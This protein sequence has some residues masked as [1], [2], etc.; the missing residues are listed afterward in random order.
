MLNI[1]ISIYQ[2]FLTVQVLEPRIFHFSLP[3]HLDK[4]LEHIWE[5]PGNILPMRIWDSTFLKMEHARTQR[6]EF[7]KFW[8]FED[9]KLW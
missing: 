5:H 2:D 4:N 3:N 6:S 9:L 8:N 1:K 7:L